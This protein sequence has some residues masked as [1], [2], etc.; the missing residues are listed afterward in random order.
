MSTKA[1]M[2]PRLKDVED[3]RTCTL[4]LTD[5]A[6]LQWG[7][8][9]RTWKTRPL[10]GFDRQRPC[11]NGATS[12]GRGRHDGPIPDVTRQVRASM[13]PR[14]KDVEDHTGQWHLSGPLKLQWGHVSR[15]WKTGHRPENDRLRR[16]ASMGPRLK[17]VEDMQ[18]LAGA[19]Y[20][21]RAS[22][23][24]RLKDVEDAVIA[25]S[26]CSRRQSLQWGHVS[27]TWKTSAASSAQRAANALQWGHVSRTW[28]TVPSL[29]QLSDV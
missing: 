23:G 12:Q 10:A 4:E 3:G 16:T 8:V 6:G 29:L 20:R 13:G 15:T 11:F 25:C 7:H 22:M 26:T 19:E 9:S 28:K 27:R 2:G 14:L 24:P 5:K 1:S 18:S 21:A 17:D